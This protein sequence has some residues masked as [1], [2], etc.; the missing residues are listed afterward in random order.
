MTRKSIVPLFNFANTQQLRFVDTCD[1]QSENALENAHNG[2][3]GYPGWVTRLEISFTVLPNLVKV[4]I[5]YL[6]GT[7]L[8][9][10]KW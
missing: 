8:K 7:V 9:I 3:S 6:Y 10:S 2:D 4:V 5:K 1:V